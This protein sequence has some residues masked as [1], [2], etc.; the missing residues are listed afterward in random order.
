MQLQ[1]MG[2]QGDERPPSPGVS[3]TR[4]HPHLLVRSDRQTL[5]PSSSQTRPLWVNGGR[6]MYCFHKV[7]YYSASQKQGILTQVPA[8]RNV[9]PSG[10]EGGTVSYRGK[11]CLSPVIRGTKS[12]QTCGNRQYDGNWLDTESFNVRA[13]SPAPVP[14]PSVS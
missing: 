7:S 6:Q 5:S 4:K 10:G 9:E 2:S 13:S 8:L 12:G 3:Q 14:A 11:C 1:I